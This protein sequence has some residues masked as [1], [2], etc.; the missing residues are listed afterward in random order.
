MSRGVLT[1]SLQLSSSMIRVLF[2]FLFALRILCSSSSESSFAYSD[3]SNDSVDPAGATSAKD[4]DAFGQII[5][6]NLRRGQADFA[7]ALEPVRELADNISCLDHFHIVEKCVNTSTSYVNLF[8]HG[9]LK[10][11]FARMNRS[12]LCHFSRIIWRLLDKFIVAKSP[13]IFIELVLQETVSSYTFDQ[14]VSFYDKVWLRPFNDH[15]DVLETF[16]IF[17]ILA[18]WI[19]DPLTNPQN[20]FVAYKETIEPTIGQL[21][22]HFGELIVMLANGTLPPDLH[23]FDHYFLVDGSHI[24]LSHPFLVFFNYLVQVVPPEVVDP[25]TS[26]FTRNIS[27]YFQSYTTDISYEI[28]HCCQSDYHG[29]LSLLLFASADTLELDLNQLAHLFVQARNSKYF[30]IQVVLFLHFGIKLEEYEIIIAPVMRMCQ[31]SEVCI[32]NIRRLIIKLK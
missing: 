32:Q 13:S 15:P 31:I 27:H 3:D 18:K 29:A 23:R 21:F 11:I 16:K 4:R 26:I 24:P 17:L 19:P 25:L 22:R 8:L 6:S 10:Y 7:S 1:S 20:R 9:Y 28:M 5:I 14:M 30:R 2:I 12:N